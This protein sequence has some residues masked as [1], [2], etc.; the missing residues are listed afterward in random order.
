MLYHAENFEQKVKSQPFVL[1]IFF[2]AVTLYYVMVT[3]LFS[4]SNLQSVFD[5]FSI[6]F[7]LR[8]FPQCARAQ[9]LD[10]KRA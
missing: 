4:Y 1:A 2:R 3:F 7:R 9:L 6:T 5:Y 8:S 10:K